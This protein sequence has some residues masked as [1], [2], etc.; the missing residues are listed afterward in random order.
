MSRRVHH[1][2][3]LSNDFNGQH[4]LAVDTVL[5]S[6]K[7]ENNPRIIFLGSFFLRILA[8]ELS[9]QFFPQLIS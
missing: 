6:I 5:R 7:P 4:I 8:Q 3:Y 9:A 2:R 1:R